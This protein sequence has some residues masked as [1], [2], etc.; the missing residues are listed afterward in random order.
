[1]TKLPAFDGHDIP[2]SGVL[3]TQPHEVI[4]LA[5]QEINGFSDL[6]LM[7]PRVL[8][9]SRRL[10]TYI[11]IAH[12]GS[13]NPLLFRLL[14]LATKEA[15]QLHS[16]DTAKVC[17]VFAGALMANIKILLTEAL[18]GCG[19]DDDWITLDLLDEHLHEWLLKNKI[20]QLRSMPVLAEHPLKERHQKSPLLPLEQL[21]RN[22]MS[23]IIESV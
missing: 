19:E 22:R 8:L 11:G 13:D 1:M 21:M 3:S 16:R 10:A 6:A 23:K 5:L 17:S 15:Q 2:V 9:V 14:G 18:Y 4:E 20:Q 12:G 7:H